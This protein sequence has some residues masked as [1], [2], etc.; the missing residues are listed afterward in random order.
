MEKVLLLIAI[1]VLVILLGLGV[2]ACLVAYLAILVGLCG[3]MIWDLRVTL[4][5]PIRP[6]VGVMKQMMT[7]G[8]KTYAQALA[9]HTHYKVD[10]YLI[11]A[12]LS[13]ADVAFYAIGAGLAER[14]LML[15]DAI[16]LVMFPK[17]ASQKSEDAAR[18][19]A[20]VCR[21]LLLLGTATAIVLIVVGKPLVTLLY[22]VSYAPAVRPMYILMG[23]VVMVGITRVLMRFFTSV[24]QHHHNIYIMGSAAAINVALNMVLI[25]RYGVLGAAASALVTYTAQAIWAVI[26]FRKLTGLGARATLLADSAD[27]RALYRMVAGL[28]LPLLAR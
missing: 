16:G 28:R 4:G 20:K 15:P 17:M 5:A 8:A 23:G 6:D 7:F 14:C 18:L 19:T 2:F 24:N 9:A 21:N 13:S 10:L 12:Y 22:G 3:W 27:V 1:A 26:V 11:A 25:P